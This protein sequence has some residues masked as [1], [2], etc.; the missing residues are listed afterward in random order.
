M[1]RQNGGIQACL[2]QTEQAHNK[3]VS[4]GRRADTN[5]PSWYAHHLLN[6]TE[7]SRFTHRQWSDEELAEALIMLDAAYLNGSQNHSWARY[8]AARLSL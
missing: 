3:T 6:H 4:G 2:T 1:K 7:L 8:C 5:W